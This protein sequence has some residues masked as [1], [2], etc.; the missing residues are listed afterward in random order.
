MNYFPP[1]RLLELY[2]LAVLY[3]RQ[4]KDT[5]QDIDGLISE[6]SDRYQSITGKAIVGARNPRRAGRKTQYDQNKA[7]EVRDAYKASGSIR[8]TAAKCGVSTTYVY[9]CIK[10]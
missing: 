6:V 7:D 1:D 8:K 3:G 5:K 2:Q 10:D 4:C 9:K